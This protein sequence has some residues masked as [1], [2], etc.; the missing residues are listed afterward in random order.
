ML[1]VSGCQDI[2]A[3]TRSRTQ[4]RQAHRTRATPFCIAREALGTPPFA[5]FPMTIWGWRRLRRGTARRCG[6][7]LLQQAGYGE[8][9]LCPRVRLLVHRQQALAVDLG[10]DL[11]R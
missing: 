2:E 11:R 8:P 1:V 5:M 4:W 10:V 6:P 7:A 9:A 3:R